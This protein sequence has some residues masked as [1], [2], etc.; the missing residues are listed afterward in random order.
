MVYRRVSYDRRHDNVGVKP[1]SVPSLAVNRGGAITLNKAA[2]DCLARPLSVLLLWDEVAQ[3]LGL[4]SAEPT[5]SRAY[6]VN[7]PAG[8][9]CGQ[10]HPRAF[11]SNTKLRP[12]IKRVTASFDVETGILSAALS[13]TAIEGES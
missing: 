12:P 11:W 9:S 10:V 13:A 4:Q 8:Y 1:S 7:Y 2:V 3:R 5:D 6:K